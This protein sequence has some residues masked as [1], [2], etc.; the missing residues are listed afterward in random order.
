M[1]EYNTETRDLS[2]LANKR[3]S[4]A[5]LSVLQICSDE[6]QALQIALMAAGT[7]IGSATGAIIAKYGCSNEEAMDI[8]FGLLRD[9]PE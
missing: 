9:N 7:A 4:E 1:M 6:D 3:V 5:V 8:L 2:H